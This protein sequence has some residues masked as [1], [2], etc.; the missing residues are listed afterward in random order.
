M[1]IKEVSESTGLSNHTL[2]YYEKEGILRPIKRNNS[3]HREFNQQELDILSF[4]SCLKDT[5]MSVKDIKE[6]TELLYE[7]D[8]TIP[9]RVE[10]L[11]KQK[12]IVD[13]KLED[14]KKAS[15]HINWKINYYKGVLKEN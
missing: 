13:K 8:I 10:L 4:L 12:L 15:D 14:I 6:F 3:G 2:R 1:T 5:F 9:K 7:G 11:E